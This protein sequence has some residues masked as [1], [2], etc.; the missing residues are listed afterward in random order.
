[1]RCAGLR[2]AFE[3]IIG[4][5]TNEGDEEPWLQRLLTEA[6]ESNTQ[7]N[8][9]DQT[10]SQAKQSDDKVFMQSYI[11]RTL[12]EVYDPERDVDLV[13]Q[14]T[15]QSLIYSDVI[16]VVGASE[17][18]KKV[19][20]NEPVKSLNKD[21]RDEKSSESAS[22]GTGSESQEDD[23]D[24]RYKERQPRGHRSEDKEVKKVRFSIEVINILI[25]D[26]LGAEKSR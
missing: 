8:E 7:E 23:Q 6:G 11:P 20:I 16:G 18:L 2:R 21:G 15:G 26:H 9:E 3:F 24:E 19:R 1:M 10:Q 22:E 14:G 5:C 12:N 17:G 25:D 4:E 13:N